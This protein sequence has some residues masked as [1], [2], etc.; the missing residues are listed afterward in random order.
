MLC[1]LF[2]IFVIFQI[3]LLI[4][5]LKKLFNLKKGTNIA[6]NKDS[7]KL[8]KVNDQIKAEEVRLIDE[9]GQMLGVLKTSQALKIAAEKSLD[10]VEISPTAEPPVCKIMDFG[11]CKYQQEKI[12]KKAKQSFKKETK[13]IRF[14][15][16]ISEN[17]INHK[18]KQ[19][20]EFLKDGDDVLVTMKF[21]GIHHR[22]KD[23]GRRI[24]ETNP[25]EL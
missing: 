11:K 6:Y 8:P 15:P 2:F 25:P 10:I 19:M 4:I 18:V 21:K 9:T 1:K 16:V 24:V 14:T 5:Q 12:D 20:Q 13:E 23:D 3:K 17:D 7:D 22:L